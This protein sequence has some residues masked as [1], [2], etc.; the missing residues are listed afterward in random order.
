MVSGQSHAGVCVSNH[1]FQHANLIQ[2]KK[3]IVGALIWCV[4]IAIGAIGL[5]RAS[6][7]SPDAGP[8][9]VQYLT[10]ATH[11]V[12]IKFP[13]RQLVAV[14]DPVF[15]AG[16]QSGRP[17]GR[18]SRLGPIEKLYR[19]P[20][21]YPD[22]LKIRFVEEATV[23]LF[24]GAPNLHQDATF[25]IQGT[26]QSTEWVVKTMLPPEKRRELASLMMQSYQRHMPEI[27]AAFEPVVK[28]S[29]KTAGSVIREDLQTAV[30]NRENEFQALGKRF[31]SELLQKK[32]VPLLQDEVWPIVEEKGAP[33]GKKIG[34]EVWE[35]LSLWRF[36]WR[37]L[38]DKSPL[39]KRDFTE[40]EF[41]RFV[42]EKAAPIL[43]SHLPEILELQKSLV[44]ELADNPKIRQTVRESFRTI[45]DDREVREL[46]TSIFKEVLIDNVQLRQ[47][48][49][50]QWTGPQ[51]RAA[52][53][54]ASRKLDPTI[55]RIGE[56]M[57]GNPNK[58]ITPE[59]A[60]VLRRMV[61]HKDQRWFLLDPGTQDQGDTQGIDQIAPVYAA[62]VGDRDA[63]IPSVIVPDRSAGS[64]D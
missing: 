37:F 4:I 23:T 18:V 53:D 41:N 59:F 62:L 61:L 14:N 17:V 10:T 21:E 30:E 24:G 44:Q 47:T 38:Y 6:T 19:P 26:P 1:S 13:S 64:V 60:R 35:E 55:N 49:E 48:V 20:P 15:L 56:A 33:L 57:F 7:D 22:A 42:Q 46:L 8:Q 25:T 43:K 3:T 27:A 16:T 39:P 54:L 5:R 31:E 36:G 52:I 51:A 9:I 34:T 40:Q 11:D 29:L 63:L 50:R 12:Q 45:A 2:S 58:E 32:I 28:D